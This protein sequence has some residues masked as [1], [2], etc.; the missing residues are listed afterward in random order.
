VPEILAMPIVAGDPDY[1][2]W[3]R[4]SVAEAA[5]DGAAEDPT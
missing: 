3:L 1:L 4:E 2:Q 5:V